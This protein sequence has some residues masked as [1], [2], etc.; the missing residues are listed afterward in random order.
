MVLKSIMARILKLFALFYLGLSF[1]LGFVNEAKVVGAS[2]KSDFI[3]K[4]FK[5]KA[6]NFPKVMV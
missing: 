1:I 6:L 3:C 4:E 2:T 5:S